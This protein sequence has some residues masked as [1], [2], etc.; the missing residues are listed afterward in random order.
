MEEEK[1]IK[2]ITITDTIE[3]IKEEMCDKYCRHRH[4]PAMTQEALDCICEKC[5]LT[6]L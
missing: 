5:P 3:E 1:V 2:R 4:D 6:R